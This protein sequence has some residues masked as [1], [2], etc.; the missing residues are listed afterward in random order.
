MPHIE[1]ILF[2]T[3][4]SYASRAAR[5]YTRWLQE[6][7][8][9]VVVLAHVFDGTALE[10]P[11]PYFFL[12]GVDSWLSERL[13]LFEE[14]GK[15]ALDEIKDAFTGACENHF[16]QGKPAL[17][18]VRF[19]SENQIDLIV[20]GTH[21]FTGLDRFVL[22]SVAEYVVRHAVCPVLTVKPKDFAEKKKSGKKDKK[23]KKSRRD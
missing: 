8:G 5:D 23:D 20:M 9:A 7:T 21:G 6:L 10:M 22:G 11:T 16:L 17:E 2:P 1:R 13:G 4:F 12:P 19:A 18:I 15:K 3:D 14:R